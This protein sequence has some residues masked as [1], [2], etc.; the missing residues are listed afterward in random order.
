M[1][2]LFYFL[3]NVCSFDNA[4]VWLHVN[5]TELTPEV[6]AVPCLEKRIQIEK[7]NVRKVRNQE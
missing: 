6:L 4:S 2:Q 7:K 1:T 5:V 3:R